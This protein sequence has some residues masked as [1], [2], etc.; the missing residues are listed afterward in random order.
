MLLSSFLL[1]KTTENT[2]EHR[3]ISNNTL[4]FSALS[5]FFYSRVRIRTKR[6]CPLPLSLFE[7]TEV[8]FS[9]PRKAH[10]R[11]RLTPVRALIADTAISSF[12]EK[13]D[14]SHR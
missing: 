13:A 9:P 10:Y 12:L 1:L 8:A 4:C 7:T 11:L 2:Q 6:L 3:E 5:V 14:I